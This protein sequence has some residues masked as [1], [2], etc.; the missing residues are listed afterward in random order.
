MPRP[1]VALI[2]AD[3][4]CSV[5]TVPTPA[6]RCASLQPLFSIIHCAT[7]T[8]HRPAMAP[9]A[10]SMCQPSLCALVALVRLIHP[11]R[12]L[13]IIMIIMIG[14]HIPLAAAVPF[15]SL[16]PQPLLQRFDSWHP[17]AYRESLCVLAASGRNITSVT[18][19][20]MAHYVGPS[21]GQ[22]LLVLH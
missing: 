19:A 15:A 8:A 14:A 7:V 9:F 17:I 12:M 1:L 22:L 4:C 21:T 2:V 6:D 18:A 3:R 11:L 13:I 16:D 10:M 20:D 5:R